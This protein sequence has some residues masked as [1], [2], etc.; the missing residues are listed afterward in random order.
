M[1]NNG[2]QENMDL[3]DGIMDL[4][5]TKNLTSLYNVIKLYISLK[6]IFLWYPINFRIS[7][8]LMIYKICTKQN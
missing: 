8:Y 3:S 1:E 6:Y 2:N 7:N 5:K 4:A